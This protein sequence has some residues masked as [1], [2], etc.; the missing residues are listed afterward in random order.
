MAPQNVTCQFATLP[1]WSNSFHFVLITFYI[2]TALTSGCLNFL[3]LLTIWKTPSLHKTSYFL[4]A[5]LTLTDF[6]SGLFGELMVVATE[7]LFVIRNQGERPFD[8]DVICKLF[9]LVA[10]SVDRLLAITLKTR[11]NNNTLLTKS[12]GLVLMASWLILIVCSIYF[13]HVL[14]ATKFNVVFLVIGIVILLLLIAMIA[15]YTFAYIKLVKLGKSTF[16]TAE[17]SN[18]NNTGVNLAKYRKTLSTFIIIC[19]VLLACYAPFSLAS[20]LLGHY[21]KKG[22]DTIFM[23]FIISEFLVFFSSTINPLLYLWR[24]KTTLL[25]KKCCRNSVGG[26]DVSDF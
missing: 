3:V 12:I 23:F 6:F 15:C 8:D 5:A 21:G 25:R 17:Q 4:I 22:N 2:T 11:Y 19:A 14:S 7:I 16:S 18:P 24:M 9:T 1:L 20:L 10:M 26:D 13:S